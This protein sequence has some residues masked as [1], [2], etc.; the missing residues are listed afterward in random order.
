MSQ[1]PKCGLQIGLHHS[2]LPG[3]TCGANVTFTYPT[4]PQKRQ[5]VSLTP[6]QVRQCF[7]GTDTPPSSPPYWWEYRNPD[8]MV[9]YNIIEAKLKE[10]NA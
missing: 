7:F 1:C 5:W 6:E 9:I 2:V 3:C 8:Y 10:K 4:Q